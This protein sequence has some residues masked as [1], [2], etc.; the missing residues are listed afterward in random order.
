[1]KYAYNLGSVSHSSYKWF[2]EQAI[3]WV[4]A[5]GFEG[6][7]LPYRAWTFNDG[8]GGAPLCKAAIDVKYGDAA[9]FARFV[10]GCGLAAGVPSLL[11]TA[12]N[13]VGA[14]LENGQPIDA[15]FDRMAKHG[16]EALEVLEGLGGRSLVVSVSPAIGMLRRLLPGRTEDELREWLY[17]G[18]V[19]VV[20][21]LRAEAQR[22]G[23]SVFLRNEYFGL[24]RGERIVGFLDRLG[25]GVGFSPDLAHL[26]IAEADTE[27]LL[28]RYADRLGSVVFDDTAYKDEVEAYASPMPEYPQTGAHQRVYCEMGQG[29]VP[30]PRYHALLAELGYDGWCVLETKDSFEFAVSLLKMANYRRKHFAAPQ[31]GE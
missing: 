7:E 9:G 21:G 2:W 13:L 17:A 14:M 30:L 20:E 3:E 19:P 24:T 25:P 10:R 31:G 5:T 23:L 27:G 1:M 18:M 12:G 22:R 16:A 29:A 26:R 6:L 8:R 28:R 4:G 15:L 11:I